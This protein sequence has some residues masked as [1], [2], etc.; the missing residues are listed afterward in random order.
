MSIEPLFEAEGQVI[1]CE[2]TCSTVRADGN[3][4]DI[5]EVHGWSLR[6]GL[7]IEA[8][9]AIDPPAVPATFG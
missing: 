7:L 3:A 2:R 8:H 5:P 6:D 4:G 9:F 1:H